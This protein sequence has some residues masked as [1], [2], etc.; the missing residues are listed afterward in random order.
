MPKLKVCTAGAAA[1]WAGWDATAAMAGRAAG[2][3]DDAAAVPTAT[4]AMAMAELAMTIVNWTDL[5]LTDL[6]LGVLMGDKSGLLTGTE[7]AQLPPG[8][9]PADSGV[10][11]WRWRADVSRGK[12]SV[13]TRWQPSR[14]LGAVKPKTA[15]VNE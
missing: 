7:R 9:A 8:H 4:A 14:T 5:R 15:E 1:A 13:A 11:H 2:L 3:A 6:R 10:R 12:A